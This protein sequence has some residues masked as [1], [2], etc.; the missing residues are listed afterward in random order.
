[1]IL[2]GNGGPNLIVSSG[3]RFV[4]CFC[5]SRSYFFLSFLAWIIVLRPFW[6]ILFDLRW[7]RMW[8]DP[9]HRRISSNSSR[10]HRLGRFKFLGEKSAFFTFILFP[11]DWLQIGRWSLRSSSPTAL[12]PFGSNLVAVGWDL[13]ANWI[14]PPSGRF[15]GDSARADFA[16]HGQSAERSLCGFGNWVTT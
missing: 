1:M 4:R 5:D 15:F 14:F 7:T 6:F 9:F 3:I 13:A 12:W 2:V 8:V 16:I 10:V 11:V